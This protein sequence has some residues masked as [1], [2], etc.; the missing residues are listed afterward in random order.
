[1]RICRRPTGPPTCPLCQRSRWK[2]SVWWLR[3][4]WRR[5]SRVGH[6]DRG[7]PEVV[8][9]LS[10]DL[11]LP[12]A[13]PE[14]LATGISAALRGR[15]NLPSRAQCQDFASRYDWS[16]IAARTAAIYRKVSR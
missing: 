4:R 15:L 7:L 8:R 6:A 12:A 5:V 10:A 3:K 9:D 13:G 16:C 14:A 11:I 1:M 2:V